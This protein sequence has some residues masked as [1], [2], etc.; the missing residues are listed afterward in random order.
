MRLTRQTSSRG[1]GKDVSSGD[2]VCRVT[3]CGT[4]SFLSGLIQ[5]SQGYCFL[6]PFCQTLSVLSLTEIPSWVAFLGGHTFFGRMGLRWEK[7]SRGGGLA[8]IGDFIS[9]QTR[10]KH[11][12]TSITS[13]ALQHGDGHSSV[14]TRAKTASSSGCWWLH[15]MVVAGCWILLWGMRVSGMLP[16]LLCLLGSLG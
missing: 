5:F 10:Q 4:E 15:L 13:K 7:D 8:L 2:T 6:V 9:T 12:K 16:C 14:T 1:G 3:V 11:F